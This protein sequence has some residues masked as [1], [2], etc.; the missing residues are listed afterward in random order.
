MREKLVFFPLKLMLLNILGICGLFWSLYI[1]SIRGRVSC[2]WYMWH[3]RH[4][5]FCWGRNDVWLMR[6]KWLKLMDLC[7]HVK[8][9]LF[10]PFLLKQMVKWNLYFADNK[11][12]KS[13]TVCD[14]TQLLSNFSEKGRCEGKKHIRCFILNQ[15]N[16]DLDRKSEVL[17]TLNLN[18]LRIPYDMACYIFLSEQLNAPQLFSSQYHISSAA[19]GENLPFH[20]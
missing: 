10:F 18:W 6:A 5:E 14:Y 11:D 20:E 19:C 15:K 7:L 17:R 3:S 9:I 8:S 12:I 13:L 2:E 4:L 1:F 16:P